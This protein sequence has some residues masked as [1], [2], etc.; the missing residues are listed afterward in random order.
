MDA[1]ARART[2]IYMYVHILKRVIVV[3][4]ERCKREIHAVC[5]LSGNVAKSRSVSL[6]SHLTALPLETF[7]RVRIYD[8]LEWT[9]R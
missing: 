7:I 9:A 1:R 3:V 4:R 2:F 5:W 6:Y 8:G